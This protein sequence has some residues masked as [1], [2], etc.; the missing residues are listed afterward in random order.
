M[1]I[2]Q[3]VNISFAIIASVGL[4][5]CSGRCDETPITRTTIPADAFDI[6]PYQDLSTLKLKHSG[7]YVISFEANKR[8]EEYSGGCEECCSVEYY[9]IG[10]IKLVPDYPIFELSFVVGGDS[11]WRYCNFYAGLNSF[12]IPVASVGSS[13]NDSVLIGENYY[14]NVFKIKSYQD[15]YQ[16]SPIYADSLY[17]NYQDGILKIIMSNQEYYEIT[18]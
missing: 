8:I 15:A 9:E 7:G 10:M 16:S 14:P 1:G 5:L 17:Y 18:Q 2:G 3:F 11:L 6:I 13:A 12:N 4:G